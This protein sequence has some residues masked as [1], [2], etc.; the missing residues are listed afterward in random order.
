MSAK[1]VKKHI[2]QQRRARRRQQRDQLKQQSRSESP[3][4]S[5]SPDQELHGHPQDA[6]SQDQHPPGEQVT[7]R[8]PGRRASLIALVTG[9][10][11]L[12]A[13]GGSVAY[14]LMA[15]EPA[16]PH[17]M[18]AHYAASPAVTERAVCPPSPSAA[19]SADEQD[20]DAEDEGGQEE[21]GTTGRYL[22]SALVFAD[23]SAEDPEA[24]WA[25]LGEAGRSES[26]Q[27]SGGADTGTPAEASTAENLLVQRRLVTG[28][29]EGGEESLMLEIPPR[30]GT[31]PADAAT[32]LVGYTYQA[33]DGPQAGLAAHRCASPQRSQWFLGPE[34]GTGS[35]SVLTLSN[36]H[37]REATVEV[38]TYDESGATGRLGSTTVLIPA[39]STR[40]VSM[41]GLTEG[42]AQIAVHVQAS[43]APVAADLQTSW[44]A[45]GTGLGTDMLPG[46]QAPRTEHHML[47]VPSGAEERPQLWLY[48]PEGESGVVELQV[49]D[50][51]GQAAIETPGVF[52]IE[53][54]QLTV[55][56]IDGLDPGTYDV[57]ARSE[58][59][60]LAAVRSAGDGQA[61]D[62]DEE[63]APD[64]S[65]SAAAPVLAE[66]SGTLLPAVGETELRFMSS[67]LDH[68]TSEQGEEIEEVP[69]EQPEPAGLFYRLVDSEGQVS[70]DI[71]VAVEDGRT[72]VVTD[73][74]L[75]DQAEDA[76][77]DDVYAVVVTEVSSEVRGGMVTR[78]DQGRFTIG[79][80]QD[81][82]PAAQYV[83]LR[84]GQ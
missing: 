83:P 24:S 73:E 37:S 58:S 50:E 80:L 13:G 84:V 63:Y 31:S 18:P 70:E 54:G 72:T 22:A 23:Q 1:S 41:A 69:E 48:A 29:A 40:S 51:Q 43:S 9:A 28:S 33:Q 2:R 11:L 36:P 57:L 46:Q 76:G 42:A 45:G 47:A 62:E 3:S 38:T 67:P 12:A 15:E 82:S 75:R 5:A 49:F 68:G 7:A 34:T 20:E 16:A 78:N 81:I 55:V 71:T 64:I 59:P 17:H 14:G 32:A 79:S 35:T 53:P 65:W 19:D 66:G 10:G 30:E 27:L 77:L 52:T 39:E 25:E 26:V 74:Q 61:L 56:D 8:R 44:T 60:T 21:Q 6:P 4:E